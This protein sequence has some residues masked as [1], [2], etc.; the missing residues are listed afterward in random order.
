[1]ILVDPDGLFNGDRLRR[2]S[3]SA[4]LHWPRLFLAS[5]GFGRLEINYA[6]IIGRAY[7]TFNPIPSEAEL[8][9]FIQ[10]YA[11]NYLLFLYEVDGRLWGQW[12]TR[13][14]FLPRYKTSIDRRSPNPP[15]PAFTE[16]KKRYREERKALPKCFGKALETFHAGVHAVA[17]AVAVAVEKDICASPNG[18][19]HVGDSASVGNL[20]R[21]TEQD[22]LLPGAPAIPVKPARGKMTPEQEQWF[23]T[24]WAEY[25]HHKGKKD[26][27]TAFAK[28]MKTEARFQEV[29]AATRAQKPEMLARPKDKRPYPATWLNG[30][31]WEDDTEEATMRPA[32]AAPDE[33]PE[34]PRNYDG[35]R[36]A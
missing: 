16:W 9:S 17:V 29:L 19:A 15:E 4:Q 33:Y 34:L 26:A 23:T 6:R 8:R 2:C 14:E 28:Y 10:E 5:D 12:D 31:R 25:W 24:W 13:K 22:G 7:P 3:N 27:R 21:D 20:P 11:Q 35:G 1:V 36:G 18:N 32:Q 30:E